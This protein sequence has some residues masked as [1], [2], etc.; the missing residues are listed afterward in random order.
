MSGGSK[1]AGARV[2]GVAES[3]RSFAKGVKERLGGLFRDD[4]DEP[5]KDGEE[6][7]G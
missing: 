5:A 2:E 7:S 1:V 6:A 3:A 4:A